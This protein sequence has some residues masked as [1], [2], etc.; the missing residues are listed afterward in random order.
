MIRR[1]WIPY[2]LCI[3]ILIVQYT[4]AFNAENSTVKN[5]TGYLAW[6]E[7]LVE[8]ILVVS[9]ATWSDAVRE[10]DNLQGG[11]IAK[12]GPFGIPFVIIRQQLFTDFQE[13]IG[14]PLWIGFHKPNLDSTW[15]VRK[16]CDNP[17][18]A[19]SYNTFSN[20][21]PNQRQCIL[22]NTTANQNDIDFSW[23]A[24]SCDERH[25][26]I[27]TKHL[28]TGYLRQYDGMAKLT[29]DELSFVNSVNVSSPEDCKQL[30]YTYERYH[31]QFHNF[32]CTTS[33]R[34]MSS[35]PV[36]FNLTYVGND[37]I[38]YVKSQNNKVFKTEID[39]PISIYNYTELP[40][41]RD[42]VETTTRSL[43][44]ST[45]SATV[46]ETA[47]VTTAATT[48]TATTETTS[49]A[50]ASPSTPTSGVAITTVNTVT[51][52][53]LR[54]VTTTGL[55]AL[56]STSALTVTPVYSAEQVEQLVLQIK[57]ENLVDVKT[58]SSYQNKFRS[59]QDHRPSSQTIGYVGAVCLSF[60]VGLLVV[61]DIPKFLGDMKTLH[62]TRVKHIT[63][64]KQQ[65]IFK[66]VV[67][68]RRK[69]E[70]LRRH[71]I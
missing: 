56:T 14:E 39:V 44:V 7:A 43:S 51:T 57:Q 15:Y 46:N 37:T 42:V 64:V 50:T 21:D 52:T 27:C 18:D 13:L 65:I 55:G 28:D 33:E 25:S 66:R 40:C 36:E 67:P 48:I 9:N 45:T 3:S 17:L 49:L 58:L 63:N 24:A 12:S 35:F 71:S 11:Y 31:C 26:F 20:D 59:A 19:A 4:K 62:G 47:T 53:A 2:I 54:A 6:G 60:L 1:L 41:Y 34:D 69:L 23:Y 70:T 30:C 10:C 32:T 22:L 5:V 68:R 16:D 8:T 38:S 61:S 29:T